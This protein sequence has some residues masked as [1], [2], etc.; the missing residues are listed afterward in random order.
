[1]FVP[2]LLQTLLKN[3]PA[4]DY[5]HTFLFSSPSH[6][7]EASRGGG[8]LVDVF[9]CLHRTRERAFTCW[10]TIME[11]R[12]TNHG[13]RI[14]L[15]AASPELAGAAARCEVWQQEEGSD[16]CPVFAEFALRV[17]PA[18][19]PPSL[20]FSAH[21]QQTLSAFLVSQPRPPGQAGSEGSVR[22]PRG[23]AV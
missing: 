6:A 2:L 20:C 1:M 11:C 23:V 18:D 10:S 15:V 19:R 21:K 5:L 16:H 9:R 13:T 8:K 3:S 17:V 4:R 12:K 14:D 7:A 22:P